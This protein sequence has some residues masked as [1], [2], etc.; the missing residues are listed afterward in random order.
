[1]KQ[2]RTILIDCLAFVAIGLCCAEAIGQSCC[3]D[4]SCCGGSCCPG[5][6]CEV[7]PQQQAAARWNDPA[8]C[9]ID[10][11]VGTFVNL[12]GLSRH[13]VSCAHKGGGGNLTVGQA[14]PCVNRFGQPL[15]ARI[16]AVDVE[17]DLAIAEFWGTAKKPCALA[18]QTPIAGER[19][20]FT[21]FPMGR[22]LRTCV[23]IFRGALGGSMWQADGCPTYGDS[24]G[25][26][27]NSSGELVGVLS[28]GAG[29]P[30]IFSNLSAVL[31]LTAQF[32]CPQRDPSPSLP[33]TYVPPIAQDPATPPPALPPG[34]QQPP[35]NNPAAAQIALLTLQVAS[36]E[37]KLASMKPC[38]C[39]QVKPQPAINY[40]QLAAEV[41]KRLPPM[42]FRVQDPRGGNY[43]TEYQA[44]PLGSY[45]TLPFGPVK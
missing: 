28:G 44:A 3:A 43:S 14:V 23:C 13:I 11:G 19:L 35:A 12:D 9:S 16:V 21:G 27:R 29:G 22:P 41:A 31:R 24:G 20:T 34:T 36:L 7:M 25:P 2:L 10:G 38:R 4:G 33:P 42:H 32:R 8:I 6:V 37:A 15:R 5:G 1:M 26:I 18:T 39:D 17:A 45:V 30:V 40:E